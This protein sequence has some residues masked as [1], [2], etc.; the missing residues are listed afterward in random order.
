MDHYLKT[1][2]ADTEWSRYAQEFRAAGGHTSFNVLTDVDTQRKELEGILADLNSRNIRTARKSIKAL[3]VFVE[4]KND[5]VDN[6]IRLGAYV[7]LRQPGR[8]YSKAK[9]A[10]VAKNLTV[11]FNR[12][13][14]LGPTFNAFFMFFNAAMQG[15]AVLANAV[16]SPRVRKMVGGH[17]GCRRHAGD[18]GQH[19]AA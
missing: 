1:G 8:S 18:H 12:R 14:A 5:A 10:S 11:N 13:G 16:R 19:A 2:R 9:A 17:C 15:T 6:A 7:A 4:R 3:G